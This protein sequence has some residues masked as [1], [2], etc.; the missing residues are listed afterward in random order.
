M[1]EAATKVPV[2]TEAKPAETTL[3]IKGEKHD[4]K[5]EKKKDY[6]LHERHFGAL[7]NPQGDSVRR[8]QTIIESI[9]RHVA[10]LLPGSAGVWPPALLGVAYTARRPTDQSEFLF[11]PNPQGE[12]VRVCRV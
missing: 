2:K 8:R 6:D 7:I 1:T 9:A 5:E 4:E 3:I 10:V 12:E 11:P